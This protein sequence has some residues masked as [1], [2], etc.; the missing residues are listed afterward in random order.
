MFANAG[1]VLGQCNTRPRL[2]H[3]LYDNYRGRVAKNNKT[4]HFYVLYS[5]KTWVFDQ[6][7]RVPG[8]IIIIIIIHQI[9][10]LARDWSKRVT[11]ANIPQLKL[12]NI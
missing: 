6:S 1:S 5:D 4:R 11:W 2:L 12:W 9:F 10:S 3:L 7:E 8:P